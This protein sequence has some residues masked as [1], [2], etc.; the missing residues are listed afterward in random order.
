MASI[1]FRPVCTGW[2]TDWRAQHRERRCP[3]DVQHHRKRKPG[4][5]V[6]HHDCKREQQERHETKEGTERLA[7]QE[8]CRWDGREQDLVDAA[9]AVALAVYVTNQTLAGTTATSFGFLVTTNGVGVSTFNVS[10]NG[11]AFGVADNSNQRVLDLLFATNDRT[12][13]GLLYDLDGDGDAA[14][15]SLHGPTCSRQSRTAPPRST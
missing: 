4:Q 15:T 1:D 14:P 3:G 9:L 7:H 5:L 8:S 2:S 11:A 10:A 13:E 12:T 6:R